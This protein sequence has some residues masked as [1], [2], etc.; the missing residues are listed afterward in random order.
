MRSETVFQRQFWHTSVTS[1]SPLCSV[2]AL[3]S[4][5]ICSIAARRLQ[6]GHT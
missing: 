5:R 1:S 6:A 4:E 3:T 2:V